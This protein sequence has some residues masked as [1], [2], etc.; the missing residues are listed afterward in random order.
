MVEVND[1]EDS[2]K[3]DEPRAEV[4]RTALIECAIPCMEQRG[5]TETRCALL[6]KR[7]TDIHF[8]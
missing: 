5:D 1:S 7:E 8:L 4:R 2:Q 3:E 6:S